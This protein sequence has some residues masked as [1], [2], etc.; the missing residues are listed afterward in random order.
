MALSLSGRMLSMSL[1]KRGYFRW[2]RRAV[3]ALLA[4]LLLSTGVVNH[5]P[6]VENHDEAVARG[7]LRYCP[8]CDG[9]EDQDKR[10]AVIGNSERS[11]IELEFLRTYSKDVTL[12]AVNADA[13]QLF[14]EKG[15]R[16]Q[17]PPRRFWI[18]GDT[19][20]VEIDGL[21][22]TFDV[23][24]AFLGVTPGAR[25][26]AALGVEISIDGSIVA[27]AH[28]RTNVEGVY[29]AGDVVKALDQINVAIGHAAIAATAIHNSLREEDSMN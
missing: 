24:Y 23:M 28:Q 14:A 18:E 27:D 16:A 12:I 4:E 26:A 22:A 3:C 11:L 9:A 15:V 10:I 1:H 20:F 29:A 6:A 13:K 19:V 17:S 21:H 25:L 8:I 2:R 5:Q 7:L